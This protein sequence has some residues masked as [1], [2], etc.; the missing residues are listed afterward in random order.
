M[1][2]PVFFE[3]MSESIAAERVAA[4]ERQRTASTVA[5][6]CRTVRTTRNSRILLILARGLQ[7]LTRHSGAPVQPRLQP[8]T[9]RAFR[10]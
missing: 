1:Y 7:R 10:R 9:T 4:A 8:T 3:M 6:E 5:A 2:N